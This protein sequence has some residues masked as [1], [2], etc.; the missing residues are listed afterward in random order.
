MSE[1]G[2][3][4]FLAG[5]AGPART[6]G[7]FPPAE[8]PRLRH[9]GSDQRGLRGSPAR[10]RRFV[11]SGSSP[12]GR[13]WV[14]SCGVGDEGH[15][16]ACANLR[17]NR[18]RQET[19]CGGRDTLVIGNYGGESSIEDGV[20]MSIWTRMRNVFRSET[21]N[22]EIAEEM[23][24][25]LAEAVADGRDPR[26][27]RRAVGSMVREREASHQARVVGWIDSLRADVGFGWGQ[28]RKRKVTTAAAVVSLALAIGACT[29]AFRLVDALFLRRLPISD[30]ARLF[31]ISHEGIDVDGKPIRGD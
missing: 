27:A 16:P 12:D 10:G 19:A 20:A 4:G 5:F 31:A 22:R 7:S 2:K 17:A 8:N 21:L 14:D 23:E 11:V 18:G 25:H 13:G 30:P 6:Q 26:E 1:Y 9:Y 3:D 24:S 29:S 15:R 28:L